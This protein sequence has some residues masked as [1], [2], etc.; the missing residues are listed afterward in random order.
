MDGPSFDLQG[1][2][3]LQNPQTGSEIY[4][5]SYSSTEVLSRRKIGRGFKLTTH[6]YLVPRLRMNGTVPLCTMHVC[7][8]CQ[9]QFYLYM[10]GQLFC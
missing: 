4:P 7:M 10:E 9:G 1:I 6:L 2:S 8:A 3:L 5:A